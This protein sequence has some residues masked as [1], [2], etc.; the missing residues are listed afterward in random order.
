MRQ[1]L[2]ASICF[3]LLQLSMPASA[4]DELGDAGK[5]AKE[6]SRKGKAGNVS[7]EKLQTALEKYDSTQTFKFLDELFSKGE[8]SD[9]HFKGRFNCIKAYHIFLRNVYL[10]DFKAEKSPLKPLVKTLLQ[11][12]MDAAYRS[13][14]DYLVMYVSRDYGRTIM[15][16]GELGLAVM[17]AI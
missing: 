4:Q 8:Q 13:E 17:Y 10:K 9:Y 7:G 6:I 14:D 2:L 1:L 15:Q 3:A 11:E 12:A 5:W 16:F